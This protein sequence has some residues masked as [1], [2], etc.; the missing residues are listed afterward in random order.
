MHMHAAFAAVFNLAAE[1][2][3]Q[4][5]SFVRALSALVHAPYGSIG[6]V[7]SCAE[8]SLEGSPDHL[9]GIGGV[10]TPLRLDFSS[11]TFWS[12]RNTKPTQ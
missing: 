11:P 9:T 6:F 12:F 3:G 10:D 2:C 4:A 5:R 1:G 7:G 8:G